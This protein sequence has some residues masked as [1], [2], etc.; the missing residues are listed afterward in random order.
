MDK[1]AQDVIK[2]KQEEEFKAYNFRNLTQQVSDLF[3]PSENQ[4][5][6]KK[7]AGEDKS[8]YVRDPTGIFDSQEMTSGLMGAWITAGKKYFDLTALNPKL[9][10]N[11]SVQS[12][13]A[14][15]TDISHREKFRSNFML[16]LNES[17]RALVDFGTCN[18]YQEWDNDHQR[19]NYRDWHISL[20]TI[21]QDHRGAVDTVI[22][23]YN[24][25]A[26]QAVAKF[27]EKA[28]AEVLKSCEKLETESKLF[29]FIHCVRPRIERNVMLL[30][31]L[32]WPF[33]SVHVNE[34]EQIVTEE[35]GYEEL[36][37]AVARW[38]KSSHEKYGR[39][40]A[41]MLLSVMKELNQMHVDFIE[42]G[43]KC[44][45]PAMWKNSN[46]VEGKINTSPNAVTEVMGNGN[47]AIGLLQPTLGGY[48]PINKEMLEF[49]QEIIHRGMFRNIFNQLTQLK[50]DRRTQLEIAEKIKEGL[51]QMVSPVSRMESE[52][53]TPDTKRSVLLLIRNGRIAP[54]PPELMKPNYYKMSMEIDA[55][56]IGVEFQGQLALAMRDYQARQFQQMS[57]F[58]AQLDQAFPGVQKPSDNISIDRGTRRML[59]SF[60][61]SE[62]DLA[63]PDEVAGIRKGRQ[64]ELNQQKQAMA[65][66]VASEAYNKTSSKADEGSPADAMQKQLAGAG[67]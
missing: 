65:A 53:F 67:R 42:F 61:V 64:Q 56:A 37:Y 23:G 6:T 33:E 27:G 43:N 18:L 32:N 5:T 11:D 49:Q 26:R 38:M 13:L 29:P 48:F 22:L 62:E 47:E 8:L 52:L 51:R 14:Y 24:L 60:G 1:I 16:Q 12:W 44:N 20:Y 58:V 46:L 66:Q 59:R 34:K 10:N 17:I 19:L 54:P 31:N 41:M 28:G 36:P 21:K 3:Y 30:D 2:M 55:D 63:T 35:G 25:T 7:T 15:A 50:G 45:Q 9:A 40:Q 39:S 57:G 4:I